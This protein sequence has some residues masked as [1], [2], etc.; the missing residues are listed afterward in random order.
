M[1]ICKVLLVHNVEDS[2]RIHG[3]GRLG[4]GN[5]NLFLKEPLLWCIEKHLCVDL[6]K[7]KNYTDNICSGQQFSSESVLNMAT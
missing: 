4:H 1:A 3:N 6:I 2:S 5:H 7:V